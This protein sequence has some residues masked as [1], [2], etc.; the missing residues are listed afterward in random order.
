MIILDTNV[1]SEIAKPD[2]DERVN[3]WFGS[4]PMNRLFTTAVSLA[5]IS[6][7]VE[8]LPNGRRKQLL[9]GR[10][11][12]IFSGVFPGRILPFDEKAARAYG[13]LVA[14]ARAKGTSIHIADG[15]IAA[16]AEVQGFT[17]ATRDTG[18]FEAAGIAV[19]DPWMR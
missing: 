13:V 19:I 14:A 15:Q 8:M 16:I 4:Q 11:K 12:E 7:G 2:V 9:V 5:E 18:P 3:F 6:F 17:I 10:T 1:I